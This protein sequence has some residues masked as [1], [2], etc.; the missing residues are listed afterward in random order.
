MPAAEGVA[1]LLV[2]GYGNPSR[3]DDGLGPA[4]IEQLCERF[5]GAIARGE[6]EVQT[7]YQL[8]VE[9]ALDLCH[10]REVVL[11]DASTREG[12]FVVSEPKPL[13]DPTFT[14]HL[15]SPAA[16]L[17]TYLEVVGEQ[18][19]KTWV[20]AIRGVEFELGAPLSAEAT[21]NLG[22]ALAYFEARWTV[23]S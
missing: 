3:G 8:Q 6:L 12:P 5:S 2:F 21:R 15:L 22:E 18:P 4:F 1:P 11:V 10:R 17:Y 9:H 20:L 14:S 7:D 13:K 16:L 19:P 23:A